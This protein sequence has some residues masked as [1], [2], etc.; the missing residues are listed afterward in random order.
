MAR[1]LFFVNVKAVL[2][3]VMVYLGW[4]L[5][6][7]FKVTAKGGKRKKEKG[8]QPVGGAQAAAAAPQPQAA[9]AQPD[10]GAG[11]GKAKHEKHVWQNNG[12]PSVPVRSQPNCSPP[13][14]T[15]VLAVCAFAHRASAVTMTRGGN[16]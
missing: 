12:G 11:S 5:P 15:S 13:C 6:G 2:N 1:I 9:A 4:K 10:N 8:R 7:G 16:A 14:T 3:T